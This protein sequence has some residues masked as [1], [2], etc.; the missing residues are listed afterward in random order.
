MMDIPLAVHSQGAGLPT[1]RELQAQ[2]IQDTD[3]NAP[4]AGSAFIP[5]DLYIVFQ[6]GE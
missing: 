2:V 4:A 1:G 3:F 5:I 6:A